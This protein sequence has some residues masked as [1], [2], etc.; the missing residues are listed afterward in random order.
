M[1][2]K[3]CPIC[4]G[5]TLEEK[6]GEYRL[7]PPPNIPGG[8][9]TVPDATWLACST[10]NEEILSDALSKAID[11]QRCKRLGLLTPEELREVRKRTGLSAVDM[12]QLLGVGEKTY[13]RWE[14]GRSIQNKSNDTLIRLLDKHAAAFS[15]IEAEREPNRD[16]L[17]AGYLQDLSRLKGSNPLAMAAHGGDLGTVIT[18]NLRKRLQEIVAR[19]KEIA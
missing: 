6:Q 14:N 16:T 3:E 12:A 7:E 19:R 5:Q 9:M 8:T 10:C 13:T 18:E 4:G 1:A 11:R 17:I 15:L 2:T